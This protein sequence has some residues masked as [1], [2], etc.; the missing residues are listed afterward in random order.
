MNP[1]WGYMCEPPSHLLPHLIPLGCPSASALSTLSRA[2]N[3]DWRSVSHMIICEYDLREEHWN[4]YI[5]ICETD[6]QS[7]FD[8][9]VF[10]G[11]FL[12]AKL[13]AIFLLVFKNVI[14]WSL[15]FIEKSDVSLTLLL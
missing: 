1:P 11:S 10:K 5:I 6:R 2:S 3:L 8:A 15:T 12:K 7:R 4:M 9:F 13:A 14:P